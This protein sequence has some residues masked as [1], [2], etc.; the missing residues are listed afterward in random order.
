MKIHIV[1]TEDDLITDLIY[2]NKN[3]NYGNGD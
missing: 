2:G 3:T 1:I